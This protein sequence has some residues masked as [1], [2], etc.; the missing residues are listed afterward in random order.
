MIFDGNPATLFKKV[1]ENMA[2]FFEKFRLVKNK[3]FVMDI[4]SVFFWGDRP[5]G[6]EK[7]VSQSDIDKAN[8]EFDKRKAE[9]PNF[10]RPRLYLEGCHKGLELDDLMSDWAIDTKNPKILAITQG[11]LGMFKGK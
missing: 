10:Y 5:C 11:K 6:R 1:E 8:I 2:K 3:D 4:T 9:D 7:A